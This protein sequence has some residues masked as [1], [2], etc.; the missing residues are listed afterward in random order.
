MTSVKASFALFDDCLMLCQV[1]YIL[2]SD[3]RT[4]FIVF[5]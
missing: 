2:S 3:I 4:I 1:Q 5:M